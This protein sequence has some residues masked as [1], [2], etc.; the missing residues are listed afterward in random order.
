MLAAMRLAI[1]AIVLAGCGSSTPAAEPSPRPQ[2]TLDAAPPDPGPSAAVMAA[3]AWVFR[4]RASG[5]D[6][7]WTLRHAGGEAMID[8]ETPAG[9]TRYLGTATD[10]E[11]LVLALSARTAKIALDCKRAQRAMG[12]ACNDAAAPP[13][14]LLDCYHPDFAA[15]MPFAAAPG[16]EYVDDATCTGYRLVAP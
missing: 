16:V 9:T 11:T 1:A 15:P 7:T 14:D 2:P 8:V 4:Y 6:E 10:G 13:V 3:P 5:R 12:T